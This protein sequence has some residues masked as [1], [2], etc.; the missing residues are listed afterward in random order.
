MPARLIKPVQNIQPSG[1]S[2]WVSFERPVSQ[3]DVSVDDD[4]S[5]NS[6]CSIEAG[7]ASSK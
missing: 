7:M 6:S 4:L 3:G 2:A 1:Q 5:Q